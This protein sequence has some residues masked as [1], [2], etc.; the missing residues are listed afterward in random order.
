ML[1][2]NEQNL[3]VALQSSGISHPLLDQTSSAQLLTEMTTLKEMQLQ[4][5]H[6]VKQE[7]GI[8]LTHA[9][10]SSSEMVGDDDMSPLTPSPLPQQQTSPL[11]MLGADD[12]FY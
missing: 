6:A 5:Q 11:S 4:Q 12:M 3:E 7:P 2:V 8:V 9:S 1:V 10:P